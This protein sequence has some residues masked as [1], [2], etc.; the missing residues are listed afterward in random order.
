MK[1]CVKK[2]YCP[3]CHKLVNCKDQIAPTGTRFVCAK[4]GGLVWS[5]E[6]LQWKHATKVA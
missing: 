3:T 5:K 1:L 4:C 2:V 6:G